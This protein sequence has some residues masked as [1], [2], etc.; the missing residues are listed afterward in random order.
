MLMIKLEPDMLTHLSDDIDTTP[1][2]LNMAS[3]TEFSHV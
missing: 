2:E 3:E 1:I